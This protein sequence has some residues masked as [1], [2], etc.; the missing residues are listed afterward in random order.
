MRM[1]IATFEE[2]T[3]FTEYYFRSTLIYMATFNHNIPTMGLDGAELSYEVC[4]EKYAAV[5]TEKNQ[6]NHNEG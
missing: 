3:F 2:N 5:W 1:E 6:P 4:A